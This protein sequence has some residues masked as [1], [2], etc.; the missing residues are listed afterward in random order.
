MGKGLRRLVSKTAQVKQTSVSTKKITSASLAQAIATKQYT[1]NFSKIQEY[2]K[3]KPHAAVKILHLFETG[4]FDD[5]PKTDMIP[6]STN[7]FR[8]LSFP[9]LK[10]LAEAITTTCNG[11]VKRQIEGLKLKSEA[12]KVVQFLCGVCDT[13][14]IPSRNIERL[15]NIMHE[16]AAKHPDRIRRFKLASNGKDGKKAGLAFDDTV[17]VFE[18]TEWEEAAQ[19]WKKIRHRDSAVSVDIPDDMVVGTRHSIIDNYSEFAAK[20]KGRR[21]EPI[22]EL[23]NTAT[24]KEEPAFDF[25]LPS[26]DDVISERG[27]LNVND[28]GAAKRQKP[29]VGASSISSTTRPLRARAS[30]ES[31]SSM[32]PPRGP[33]GAKQ[34]RGTS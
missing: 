22:L 4:V 12:L 6:Q 17:G 34:P 2:L 13:C 19:K 20:I 24:E 8:L 5:A 7:K 30:D 11:D 1:D 23:F 9:L 21:T 25:E 26:N 16:K 18:F 33:G 28:E 15:S 29:A 31:L 27:G 10:T 3:A 32:P 14:A